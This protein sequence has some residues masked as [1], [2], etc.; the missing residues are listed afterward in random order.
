MATILITDDETNIRNHLASYIRSLGHD[1][2]TA[3][4]GVETLAAVGRRRFDVVFSDVRMARMDGLALLGELRQRAPETTVVLMTAYATI[5]QAVEAIRAGAHD[6]LVKPFGLDQIDVVLGRILEL[7]SL[8]RENRRLRRAAGEALILTSESAAMQHALATAER[9]AASDAVVLLTG[10]SGTGKTVL[11]RQIHGWSRRA[12]GP[13]VTIACTTLSDHLLE[14]E[15]FGHARGALTGAL[16]D[17]AGRVEAAA[18]GTLFFDEIGELPSELQA[19]LLRFLDERRFERV[20]ETVTRTVDA[21]V[22]AATNRAL[23]QDVAT[24]RFREDLFFRLNVVSIRLPALRERREDLDVFVDHVLANVAARDRRPALRLAPAARAALHRYDWPGNLRELAN[25]LEHAAVLSRGDEIGPDDLPDR[26]LAGE[27]HSIDTAGTSNVSLEEVE[28]RH[29]A[30]VL[31]ESTTL[32]EAAAR[33]G[34]D[35]TTLW[36]KRKRYQLNW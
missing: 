20:G 6:Y 22:V 16:K 26:L 34:V 19:K 14:S 24:G 30:R 3:A 17:K 12:A 29:I 10:E 35:V 31:A 28:K 8:R 7:Q 23:E 32:E 18:G 21:R 36:R 33:L 11:A 13:F 5:A 27:P 25:A 2:E 1:V 15:L 4:D 9:A